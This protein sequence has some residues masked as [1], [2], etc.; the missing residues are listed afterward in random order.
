LPSSSS[1]IPQNS[2]VLSFGDS[3]LQLHW[4]LPPIL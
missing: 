4:T 2:Q 1:T 3:M